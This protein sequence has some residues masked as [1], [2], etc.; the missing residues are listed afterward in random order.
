MAL[1]CVSSVV[2]SQTHPKWI[3]NSWQKTKISQL[4]DGYLLKKT[5]ENILLYYFEWSWWTFVFW[6]SDNNNCQKSLIPGLLCRGTSRLYL[7]LYIKMWSI[8]ER[9]LKFIM[10]K[11]SL[12]NS[13]SWTYLDC[14]VLTA[15]FAQC[16]V[17]KK[18]V[19]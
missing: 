13:C 6:N 8:F 18:I 11:F 14:N 10:A 9:F 5:R 17:F 7:L 3:W 15:F 1:W 4:G 16:T 12:R 19:I 2:F